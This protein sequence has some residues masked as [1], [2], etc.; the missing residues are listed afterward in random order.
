MVAGPSSRWEVS[1]GWWLAHP[2]VGRCHLGGGWPILTLGGVTWE[3]T[4]HSYTA[5]QKIIHDLR[6]VDNV[7]SGIAVTVRRSYFNGK[8]TL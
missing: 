3:V 4:R 1:L 8:C 7:A 5:R 6:C 2:H